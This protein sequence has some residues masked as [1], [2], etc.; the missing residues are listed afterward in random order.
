MKVTFILKDLTDYAFAKLSDAPDDKGRWD[1]LKK[2]ATGDLRHCVSMKVGR[3][4]FGDKVTL[5][6][7]VKRGGKVASYK[8]EKR[9]GY[10]LATVEWSNQ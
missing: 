8:L 6:S 9:R 7:I 5:N 1:I 2:W 10:R 4:G 3:G